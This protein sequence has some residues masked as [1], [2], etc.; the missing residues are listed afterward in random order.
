MTYTN[1]TFYQSLAKTHAT[2]ARSYAAAGKIKLACEQQS[3]AAERAKRARE[4]MNLIDSVC[5]Q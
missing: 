4:D 1:P 3:K 5:G 2:I